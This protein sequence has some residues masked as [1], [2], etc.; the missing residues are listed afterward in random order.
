[1][2][3][4]R[5]GVVWLLVEVTGICQR[6]A[7]AMAMAMDG[8]ATRVGSWNRAE[9]VQ[10]AGFEQEGRSIGSFFLPKKSV[11]FPFRRSIRSSNSTN[12]PNCQS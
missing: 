6:G 3:G 9:F 1:M 8:V 4:D 12:S 11:L 7:M 2:G 10:I 5:A